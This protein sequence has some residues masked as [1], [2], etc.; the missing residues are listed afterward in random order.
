MCIC[1]Q[2]IEALKIQNKIDYEDNVQGELC[3]KI[4]MM[5]VFSLLPPRKQIILC[6]TQ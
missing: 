3:A 6:S 2:C 5:E 1:M 4:N